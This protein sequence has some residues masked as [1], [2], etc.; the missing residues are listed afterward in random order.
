[1]WCVFILHHGILQ[2]K[3]DKILKLSK[4]IIFIISTLASVAFIVLSASAQ[5][6]STVE[7]A[8]SPPKD[9]YSLASVTA[10]HP[11]KPPNT[12]SPRATLES[13][14]DYVNQSYRVL[15]AAHHKNLKTPGFFTSEAVQEMAGNA[16]GLFDRAIWCLN[17]SQVPVA[18]MKDVSYEA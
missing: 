17:L 14:I 4:L 10:Q 12:S 7:S 3:G 5:E 13:F 1:L 16:E 9:D 18:R 15:M 6:T 11:L 8:S 2:P